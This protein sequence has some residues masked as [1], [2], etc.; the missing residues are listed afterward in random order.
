M[1]TVS[2]EVY[3]TINLC[4]HCGDEV[5]RVKLCEHCRTKDKREEMHKKN[6]DIF[7]ESGFKYYCK[8]CRFVV[9]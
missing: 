7:A 6:T 5:G 3:K 4:M 2:D 1:Q 8:P 9:E